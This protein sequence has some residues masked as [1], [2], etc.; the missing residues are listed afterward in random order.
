MKHIHAIITSNS[1]PGH[2]CAQKKWQLRSIHT[3]TQK[4]IV[5][6]FVTPQNFLKTTQ[7]PMDRTMWHIH[8]VYTV[9]YYCFLNYQHV[10]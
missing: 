1:T 7:M 2:V 5:V 4:F 8:T 3:V 6:S 9:E 10:H